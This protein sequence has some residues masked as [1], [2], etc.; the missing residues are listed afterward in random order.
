MVGEIDEEMK[1]IDGE[2]HG[3]VRERSGR[4]HWNNVVW[5]G[6]EWKIIDEE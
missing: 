5:G 2:P 3:K 6:E 4:W 1:G